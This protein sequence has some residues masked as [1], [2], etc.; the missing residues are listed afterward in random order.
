MNGDFRILPKVSSTPRC[1]VPA[2]AEQRI[3]PCG[4]FGSVKFE[5]LL[6]LQL[7]H[8]KIR[9]IHAA[10]SKKI[11]ADGIRWSLEGASIMGSWLALR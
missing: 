2:V 5:L 11:L 8:R 7:R 10:S 9:K 3:R 4:H 1:K 6:I